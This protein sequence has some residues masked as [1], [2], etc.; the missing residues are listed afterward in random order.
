MSPAS[1][2]PPFKFL[3]LW[4]SDSRR[5]LT[6]DKLFLGHV[7]HPHPISLWFPPFP[8]I[9]LGCGMTGEPFIL[10][11]PYRLTHQPHRTHQQGK[12]LP[13]G[14]PL[15]SGGVGCLLNQHTLSTHSII[16]FIQKGVLLS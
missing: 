16:G 13:T 2:T 9:F 14:Y 8:L 15:E 10:R 4:G 11:S 12:S 5:N 7:P 3:E 1:N 6:T